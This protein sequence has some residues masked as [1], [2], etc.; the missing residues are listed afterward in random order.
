MQ[1]GILLY[2]SVLFTRS[3]YVH[4]LFQ[5]TIMIIADR[6]AGV[7]ESFFIKNNESGF[8][9]ETKAFADSLIFV[10]VETPKRGH[11][12]QNARIVINIAWVI[13]ITATGFR[14]R[15]SEETAGKRIR[16]RPCENTGD[17][18]RYGGRSYMTQETQ[19][20]VG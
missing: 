14:R 11:A 5:K 10:W 13:V 8:P 17:E 7:Y 15:I 18:Y 20:S 1:D 16:S 12:G 9:S 2:I 6:A 4:K 19:D 3:M